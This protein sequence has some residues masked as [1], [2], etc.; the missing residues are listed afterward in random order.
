MD[1]EISDND[2]R[3]ICEQE[4][5]ATRALGR[6]CARRLRTRLADLV[7]AVN[8]R[9]LAAGRPHPLKGDRSGQ[10]SQDLHGGVRLVFESANN[11]IPEQNNGGI[12]WRRVTRVRIVFI[13]DYHD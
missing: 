3:V 1:I 6:P 8:V 10:F 2:L 11:P 7:A 12:D 5:A 4:R 13:G 9:E